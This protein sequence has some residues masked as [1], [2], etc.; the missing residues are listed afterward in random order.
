MNNYNEFTFQVPRTLPI[1]LLLD[2]SASMLRDNKIVELNLAVNE[3]VKVLKDVDSVHSAASLSVITFGGHAKKILELT[4]VQ[5]VPLL[6]FEANGDTPLGEALTIAKDMIEDKEIITSRTYRPVV[7]LVSDGMPNDDWAEPFKIFKNEGRSSKCYCV[8]MGIGE[9]L[10]R[11][12]IDILQKF[13]SGQEKIFLA[14]EA[15]D[16][17]KFFGLVSDSV[18]SRTKSQNPNLITSIT[19][20][21]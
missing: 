3:M 1:I 17:H 19:Q 15:K 14:K 7:V 18:V 4:S 13:S 2:T 9:D 16:I 10:S 20:N 6:E 8:S 12:A 5:D 11:T 21:I